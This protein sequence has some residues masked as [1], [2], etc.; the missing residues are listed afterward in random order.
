MTALSERFGALLEPVDGNETDS[1]RPY[2]RKQ[3]G[4]ERNVRM[5]KQTQTTDPRVGPVAKFIC[6]LFSD[7]W[8]H[9]RATYVAWARNALR[10]A[11]Q[12][13]RKKK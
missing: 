2:W 13:K 4:R 7:D 9:F 10:V 12:A 5:D 8:K 3:Q 11:D 6:S 1:E